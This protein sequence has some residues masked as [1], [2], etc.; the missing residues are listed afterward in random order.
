MKIA[1][2][3]SGS[4][5]EVLNGSDHEFDLPASGELRHLI[6][7]VH[8]RIDAASRK[9]Y[10]RT[11]NGEIIPNRATLILVNGIE[12]RVLKGLSTELNEETVIHF[13]TSVHGG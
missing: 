4:F 1:A 12:H 3:F 13:I 2:K 6:S 9:N 11:E 7:I 5:K 8:E 10:F